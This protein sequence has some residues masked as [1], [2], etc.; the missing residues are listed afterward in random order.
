MSDDGSVD[1]TADP[2]AGP[3][4]VEVAEV[5]T[6]IVRGE[7]AVSGLRDFFDSS[8]QVLPQ[9]IGE[10]GATIVG[11]AYALFRSISEESWD[12]DVGFAVDRELRPQGE[13]V[14][15]RLPAGRVAR[16]VHVGGF[17]GLGDAWDRLGSWIEEQGANAGPARWE[18]YHTRP[19]PDMDP[20]LLRTELNWLLSPS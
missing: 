9:V 18:V 19:A 7:V 17:D 5:V 3:V 12:L 10:Q 13:V 15:D 8:F 6:A 20:S 11:P 14:A 1:P 4:V 16:V 2:T